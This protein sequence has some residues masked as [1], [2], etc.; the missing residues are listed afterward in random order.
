M[1]VATVDGLVTLFYDGSKELW[2]QEL[3]DEWQERRQNIGHVEE[4]DNWESWDLSNECKEYFRERFSWQQVIVEG[5]MEIPEFT[6]SGCFNIKRVIFADTVIRIEHG[7]FFRCYN[8]VFIKLSLRLEYIGECAFE[9]CNLSSVFVP[10]SCREIGMGAFL[11][12]IHI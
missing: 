11:S 4:D 12:L 3:I 1:R 7:A 10:P 5:V 9:L 8:L 2:N 6:F